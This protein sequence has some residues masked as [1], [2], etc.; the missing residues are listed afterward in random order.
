M[1]AQPT[2][3]EVSSETGSLRGVDLV[4]LER[5]RLCGTARAGMTVWCEDVPDLERPEYR[6]A[7]LRCAHCGLIATDPYPSDATIALLYAQGDSSDYEFPERGSIAA[8]KERLAARWVKKISREAK[9]RPQ[10]ILDFGTGAG[11]YAAAAARALPDAVV[12][13]T[14]FRSAAPSGSYFEAAL[15][16]LRYVSYPRV[17]ESRERFDLIFARHVLEHTGDPIEMVRSW[18]RMLSPDGA[19]YIEIPNTS[20]ATAKLL[21]R[22][23]PLLYVPKHLSHFTR[24]TLARTIHLAGGGARISRCEMP[25]MGNVLA[26]RMGHSRFDPRFR[27]PGVLLHPVQLALEAF[28]RQGTCLYALVRHGSDRPV[29]A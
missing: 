13:G 7:L 9:V 25:M 14:D 18:L 27:L 28:A 21:E 20:S 15:P 6:Y 17:I 24:D 1:N 22:R 10:R 19:L 29:N 2:M 26:L 16:N 3:A 12:I 4:S 23:W 5:C 8:L 11:R